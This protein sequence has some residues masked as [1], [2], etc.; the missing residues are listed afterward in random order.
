MT[1]AVSND[2]VEPG[3]ERVPV[4]ITG[5]K[6]LGLWTCLA[7][8]ATLYSVP[9][10]FVRWNLSTI[11]PLVWWQMAASTAMGTVFALPFLLA[12]ANPAVAYRLDF[13]R[14]ARV[15]FGVKGAALVNLSRGVLGA[16]LVALTTL[17]G[18]EAAYGLWGEISYMFFDGA[19][20]PAEARAIAYGAF[21]LAQTIIA[22]GKSAGAKVLLLGRAAALVVGA[23]FFWSWNAGDASTVWEATV[24]S[25]PALNNPGALV[26]DFPK[27]FWRHAL[28][29]TGVWMTLG[30]V[31]PDYAQRMSSAGR[32]AKG[33]IAWLPV[34]TACA[35]LV[36]SSM[37]QAPNLA[38]Y[39]V[40][41]IAALVTNA[42]ANFVGP[43]AAIGG[44]KPGMGSAVLVSVLIACAAPL[45]MTWQQTVAV[46]S[47]AVGIGSLL[48]APVAGVMLCD[49]WIMRGR[50]VDRSQ[51]A[52]DTGPGGA[53]HYLG[54]V[55]L[56]AVLAFLV[57]VAPDLIS[58]AQGASTIFGGSASATAIG[59]ESFLS[60]YVVNMEYSSMIGFGVSFVAY[61]LLSV[62][63]TP[64]SLKIARAEARRM[65]E[66]DDELAKELAAAKADPYV[67]GP[68]SAEYANAK[69]AESTEYANAVAS[70][71]PTSKPGGSSVEAAAP[72]PVKA[73]A[74]AKAVAM[75]AAEE[76]VAKSSAQSAPAFFVNK[77]KAAK[78]EFIV[79]SA[80]DRGGRQEPPDS[81]GDD[82]DYDAIVEFYR[83]AAARIERSLLPAT[84]SRTN[85]ENNLRSLAKE[86]QIMLEGH[87][88]NRNVMSMVEV[89]YEVM[90]M[91]LLI[92]EAELAAAEIERDLA[93][94]RAF[95]EAELEEDAADIEERLERDP[96]PPGAPAADAVREAV[97]ARRARLDAARRDAVDAS[98]TAR[99]A[100]ASAR[101]ASEAADNAAN[102][103]RA[104]DETKS[105]L[106][107]WAVA[108][109]TWELPPVLDV[110]ML[111]M[112]DAEAAQRAK[113]D[114]R[115][116]EY[117]PKFER[118]GR[119]SPSAAA[120]RTRGA[121][122]PRLTSAAW[123]RRSSA[124]ARRRSSAAEPPPTRCSASRRSSSPSPTRSSP[125]SPRCP[126]PSTSASP[127]RTRT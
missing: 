36:A 20:L 6:S 91:N 101:N 66:E 45:V 58:V 37:A 118:R 94:A 82:V 92:A 106:R 69:I 4:S 21:W 30:T 81:D 31:L 46:A 16:A 80:E 19:P 71:K 79:N 50:V 55:N 63:F 42:V 96:P 54:G 97:S 15:S 40:V 3:L 35:A 73:K 49:Y 62:L 107:N 1:R 127:K 52:S 86:R 110:P 90:Q 75:I 14:L 123:R 109:G 61:L 102:E 85:A 84:A 88:E 77:S 39:S 8:A 12:I 7:V 119:T 125:P 64:D 18:G 89:R 93:E 25:M 122:P 98:G 9:F 116:A 33:Q 126:T 78:N 43:M 53:Y 112:S 38:L 104:E 57:G 70:S 51:L 29:T 41:M 74:K 99:D 95:F 67:D 65:K 111:P 100:N 76:P 103:L 72:E 108:V 26:P 27:E 68:A 2:G 124:S 22:G 117:E 5:Q 56:R 48:V 121:P 47:W 60:A 10:G 24:A 87:V 120:R 17:I 23:Y 59:A 34:L 83:S 105:L 115:R 13:P 11:A 114:A 44:S 28:M 113:E 32:V